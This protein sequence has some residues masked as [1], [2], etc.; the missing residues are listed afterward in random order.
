MFNGKKPHKSY[1]NF[2]FALV[3][4][5]EH[6]C[7]DANAERYAGASCRPAQNQ[8]N[9][10]HRAPRAQSTTTETVVGRKFW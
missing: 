9:I 7:R 10:G 3:A 2:Y 6:R 4:L 8:L 5:S 1:W